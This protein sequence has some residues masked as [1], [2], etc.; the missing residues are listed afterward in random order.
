MKNEGTQIE[1]ARCSECGSKDVRFTKETITGNQKIVFVIEDDGSVGVRASDGW[2]KPLRKI[3]ATNFDMNLH[4]FAYCGDCS[5]EAEGWKFVEF[6][7]EEPRD[8]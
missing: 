4:E 8:A 2:Y 7:E 1:A 3:Q 5:I 6:V